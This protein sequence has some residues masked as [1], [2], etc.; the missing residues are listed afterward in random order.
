MKLKNKYPIIT[1]ILN[2][3]LFKILLL[4]VILYAIYA[5]FIYGNTSLDTVDTL[6]INFSTLWST[7][8]IF[9]II[10][11]I[12]VS[13]TKILKEMSVFKIRATNKSKEISQIVKYV[14][15]CSFIY[16][17]IFCFLQI[18]IILFTHGFVRSDS[19]YVDLYGLPS[20][21]F[22]FFLIRYI[23]ITILYAILVTC[24]AYLLPRFITIPLFIIVAFSLYFYSYDFYKVAVD[25]F[26]TK[27]YIG[28][29][30]SIV[31]YGSFI[32]EVFCSSFYILLLSFL[33]LLIKKIF[34]SPFM[35]NIRILP[36]ILKNDFL[37]LKNNK[38]KLILV[39]LC[40]IIFLAIFRLV[41]NTYYDDSFIYYLFGLKMDQNT[42]IVSIFMFLI[43]IFTFIY[44]AYYLFV[45]DIIY[46]VSNYFLRMNSSTW[47]LYKSLSI[48]IITI[49]LKLIYYL[50]LSIIVFYFTGSISNIWFY[51]IID[52]VFTT[53][54]QQALILIGYT[55]IFLKIITIGIVIITFLY[56][57]ISI[58]DI[59]SKVWL[60]LGIIILFIILFFVECQNKNY[61]LF[62]R[63]VHE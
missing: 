30:Y 24:F 44:I 21:Y 19:P 1:F 61:L 9:L 15:I 52:I 33:Y 51:F 45:K 49:V 62:E 22:L 13:I 2:Q 55:R 6:L 59:G 31:P 53:F 28:Y 63:E 18:I 12:S 54:L 7:I 32:T 25:L 26:D 17:F 43:Y 8:F 3:Q 29:Y 56:V 5:G 41:T 60:L 16:L 58:I 47:Y 48:L 37:S 11:I 34:F 42:D 23:V 38:K 20:L 40:F 10:T 4:I 36:V 35:T 57:G 46:Q 14:V 27:L 39:F 50:L